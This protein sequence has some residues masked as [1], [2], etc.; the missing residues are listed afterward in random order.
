MKK[1]QLQSRVSLGGLSAIA[2]GIGLAATGHWTLA[3]IAFTCS[4]ALWSLASHVADS[5]RLDLGS[6][7]IKETRRVEEHALAMKRGARARGDNG[8]GDEFRVVATTAANIRT[9]TTRIIADA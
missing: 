4:A 7:V 8:L 2:I 1:S 5:R 6:A 3:A 9:A